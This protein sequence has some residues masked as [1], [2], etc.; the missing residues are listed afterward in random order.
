MYVPKR[1]CQL[2]DVYEMTQNHYHNWREYNEVIGK[3]TTMFEK[4]N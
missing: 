2:D 4:E 3:A 1:I